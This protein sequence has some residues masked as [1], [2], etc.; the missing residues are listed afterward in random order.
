MGDEKSK[1]EPKKQKDEVSKQLRKGVME[2]LVLRLLEEG[3]SYGYEIIQTLSERSGGV[4]L[5][6][7]GTLYP[8]LYR[9]EDDGLVKSYWEQ[10]AAGRK[11][12]KKYYAITPSGKK[13]LGQ[14][15]V[16]WQSF[17]KATDQI[18]FDNDK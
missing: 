14:M 11:V 17:V 1:I 15:L 4:F 18:L 2:I 12:P 9:L 10:P 16:T 5:L 6:K 7:E 3:D 13:K 8:V